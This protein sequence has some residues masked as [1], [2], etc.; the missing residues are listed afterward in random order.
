MK[1]NA[2]NFDLYA[3][4][5]PKDL[6]DIIALATEARAELRRINDHFDAIFENC[7][8]LIDA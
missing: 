5:Q 1:A 4:A 6:E 7:A 3:L 8:P 2:M